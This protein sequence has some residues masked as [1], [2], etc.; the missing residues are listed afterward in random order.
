MGNCY[1]EE[2]DYRQ[3]LRHFYYVWTSLDSLIDDVVRGVFR[4][5]WLLPNR[6]G[7]GGFI[8]DGL[9]YILNHT[10]WAVETKQ[11]I[12]QSLPKY[13]YLQTRFAFQD[14][15][16]LQQNNNSL[17][18][19]AIAKGCESMLVFLKNHGI[20]AEIAT[21]CLENCSVRSLVSAKSVFEF[22]HENLS[23]YKRYKKY[24]DFA[25]CREGYYDATSKTDP[26]EYD[27]D[28]CAA[29]MRMKNDNFAKSILIRNKFSQELVLHTLSF[30]VLH[31]SIFAISIVK[32][33]KVSQHDVESILPPPSSTLNRAERSSLNDFIKWAEQHHYH[34]KLMMMNDHTEKGDELRDIL[35]GPH[36]HQNN[37]YALLKDKKD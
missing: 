12:V 26:E 29:A 5:E 30:A 24:M 19:L 13:T 34:T 9:E 37:E 8:V 31:R 32:E 2:A 7:P 14:D 28:L 20:T 21:S 35:C 25:L 11:C 6:F 4:E 1:G 23:L 3:C 15:D 22:Q 27:Y 18:K 36:D 17:L 16:I 33:Q 10:N